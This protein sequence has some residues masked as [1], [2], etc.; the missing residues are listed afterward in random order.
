MLGQQSKKSEEKKR[1]KK[2][3]LME[4]NFMDSTMFQGH[5]A[6]MP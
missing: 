6:E 1:N 5:I 4:I 3:A 2:Q